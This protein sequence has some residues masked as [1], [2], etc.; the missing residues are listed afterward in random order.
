MTHDEAEAVSVRMLERGF[1]WKRG[2]P[3]G[4]N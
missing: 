3:S 1:F 2:N 4:R